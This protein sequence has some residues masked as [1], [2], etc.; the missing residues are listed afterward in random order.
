MKTLSTYFNYR[1]WLARIKY[2]HTRSGATPVQAPL[3]AIVKQ[4]K[5]SRI[6]SSTLVLLLVFLGQTGFGQDLIKK[7]ETII[8]SFTTKSK[9]EVIILKN[10]VDNKVF[11]RFG[12]RAKTEFQFP[13]TSANSDQKLTYSFYVRGGGINNEGME[14]NYIYFINGNFQYVVYDTYFFVEN[15]HNIGVRVIDLKTK[16]ITDI[17]GDI[18]TRK[19]TLTYFRDNQL[20]GIG[21]ELFD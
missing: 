8:F 20:I 6:K 21:E 5:H 4:S 12:S 9:K 11:Y 3:V 18:K 14:L 19:G 10:N 17:P 2:N 13:Q 15:R 16:K 7:G 1:I